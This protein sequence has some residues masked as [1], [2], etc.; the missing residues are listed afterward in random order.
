MKS[1]HCEE[2]SLSAEGNASQIQTLK[3]LKDIPLS[4]S[5]PL[6]SEHDS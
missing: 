6:K 3:R 1:H 4:H 2:L 5:R